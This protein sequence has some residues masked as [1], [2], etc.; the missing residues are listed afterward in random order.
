[1][2]QHKAEDTIHYGWY[3]TDFNVCFMICRLLSF[4]IYIA[5]KIR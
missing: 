5:N 1:M 4:Y 2:K 3:V